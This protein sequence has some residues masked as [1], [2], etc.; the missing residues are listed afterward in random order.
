MGKRRIR[1]RDLTDRIG[2]KDG[3]LTAIARGE[4][5]PHGK[6]EERTAIA[7]LS[8]IGGLVEGL[9]EPESNGGKDL[10]A[11][12][13]VHVMRLKDPN[14]YTDDSGERV[15]IEHIGLWHEG[16]TVTDRNQPVYESLRAAV[17]AGLGNNICPIPDKK[18]EGLNQNHLLKKLEQ[19]TE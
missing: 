12:D 11:G 10:G 5:P 13:N 14:I 15:R 9:S 19:N 1:V 2:T 18:V 7:V 6:V 16:A 4:L 8:K 17:V 3:I